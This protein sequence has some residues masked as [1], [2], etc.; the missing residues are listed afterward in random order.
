MYWLKKLKILPQK[1]NF[2]KLEIN[3][4]NFFGYIY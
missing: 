3:K 4:I 1:I 2:L